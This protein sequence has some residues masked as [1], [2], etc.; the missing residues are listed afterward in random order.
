MVRACLAGNGLAL[1]P[2]LLGS[3]TGLQKLSEGPETIREIWLLSHRDAGSIARFKV[4]ADW[5]NKPMNFPRP[6]LGAAC[7]RRQLRFALDC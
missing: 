6:I 2:C 5:L 4:V 1:L 7:Q 3:V